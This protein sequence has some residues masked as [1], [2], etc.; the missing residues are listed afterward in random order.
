MFWDRD[1]LLLALS[2]KKLNL[3]IKPQSHAGLMYKSYV[4]FYKINF[5][6]EKCAREQSIQV[7]PSLDHDLVFQRFLPNDDVDAERQAL[8]L[9]GYFDHSGLYRHLI[10]HLLKLGITVC[11]FDLPGHGLSSGKRAAISSF[12]QYQSCFKS[13]LTTQL[14]LNKPA[15]LIGQSTG[16]AIIADTLSSTVDKSF[17]GLLLEDVKQLDAIFLAPLLK[18]VAWVKAEILHSLLRTRK[19]Y[20]PRRF[21]DNSH[22]QEFLRF[23]KDEDPLQHQELSVEWVGAL[24]EW[25][26]EMLTR[27]TYDGVG[28]ITI[29]QGTED[30]TVDWRYNLNVYRK[31]FP[32][33]S[34]VTIK[35]AGHHLVAESEEYRNKVF[36]AIDRA[37]GV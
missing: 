2:T 6:A 30:E 4:D 19:T 8:L 31:L 9:H 10:K 27:P 37:I 13:I 7:V 23:I 22:D 36:A 28:N 16:A 33:N 26:P 21:L 11:I 5:I 17:G 25:L 18:P 12:E 34:A 1:R 15:H 32:M 3:S 24:R 20:W 29:I 14:D 35:G